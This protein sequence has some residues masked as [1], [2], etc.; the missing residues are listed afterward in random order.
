MGFVNTEQ[1]TAHTEVP[2]N[3]LQDSMGHDIMH[4]LDNN[5][6]GLWLLMGFAG[7][8]VLTVFRKKIREW[9]K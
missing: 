4:W 7:I 9:L 6:V 1:M 2:D 3:S 8:G 5:G